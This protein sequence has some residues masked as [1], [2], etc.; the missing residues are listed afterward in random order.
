MVKSMKY[1]LASVGKK[2][3]DWVRESAGSYGPCIYSQGVIRQDNFPPCY[4]ILLALSLCLGKRQTPTSLYHI[5][6]YPPLYTSGFVS[7]SARWCT[8]RVSKSIYSDSCHL[9]GLLATW[10]LYPASL[11]LTCSSS[12]L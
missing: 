8:P 10:P 3:A 1:V 4:P 7:L 11:A 12:F 2:G 5:S 9:P 6:A